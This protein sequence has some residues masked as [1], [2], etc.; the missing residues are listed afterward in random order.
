MTSINSFE[1]FNSRLRE[2][3]AISQARSVGMK[4]APWSLDPTPNPSQEGNNP[5]WDERLLP[6]QIGPEAGFDM[7]SEFNKLALA[8]FVLQF[9]HVEPYRRLCEARGITP[10]KIR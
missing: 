2:F 1:A 6:S 7:E 8:L 5:E 9:A 3:M 10:D 4:R